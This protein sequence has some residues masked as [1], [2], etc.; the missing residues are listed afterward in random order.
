[1]HN[2]RFILLIIT[3]AIVLCTVVI[4]AACAD[5]ELVDLET[6]AKEAIYAIEGVQYADYEPPT[7]TFYLTVDS[8]LQE[9]DL[10]SLPLPTAELTIY[11]DSEL[12][13]RALDILYLDV[14]ANY[15]YLKFTRDEETLV[16]NLTITRSVHSE[17]SFSA[18]VVTTAP[19]CTEIGYQKR[20]CECGAN[21]ID[22]L[23]A[24]GHTYSATITDPTCTVS[25]YTHHECT[26]CGDYYNDNYVDPLSHS[27]IHHEAK[28][29]SCEEI[30]Y[31]EYDT[32]GRCDYSTY[33]ELPALNHRFVLSEI[34]VTCTT[35]GYTLHTCVRC[36]NNETTDIVPM[37]GHNL[38]DHPA[39]APTCTEQGW[40]AYETCSRCTYTS[41]V[42]LPAK[43]HSWDE[44]N[45]LVMPSIETEG[46]SRIS[47][48]NCDEYYEELIDKL[49]PS[50]GLSFEPIENLYYVVKGIGTC[51]DT[52]LVIPSYY[53][54]IVVQRIKTEAFKNCS[55][56]TSVVIPNTVT[57]I[58]QSAF[59][60][61]SSLK[62]VVLGQSVSHIED[63]AFLTA[64]L[65][66]DNIVTPS[67]LTSFINWNDKN[68]FFR[69]IDG[70]LYNGEG[71]ALVQYAL[72]K[73]DAS[74]TPP[75]GVNTI[76][77][78]ALAYCQN[79]E[80][81]TLSE[82]VTSI[83]K[84]VFRQCLALTT[85]SLPDTLLTLGENAFF[86]CTA[87]TLYEDD[88]AYY[89]GNDANHYLVTFRVKENDRTQITTR[90]DTKILYSFCF[91]SCFS[92]KEISI[93]NQVV[94]IGTGAFSGCSELY[95]IDIPNNVLYIDDRAFE[96]CISMH[97]ATIGTGVLSVGEYA[98][99][100][101]TAL[102]E[103]IIPKSLKTIA[104]AMFLNCTSLTSVRF[105]NG[106]LVIGAYAFDHCSSLEY[107]VLPSTLTQIG[108]CAFYGCTAITRVY[109]ESDRND[110]LHLR[111][112]AKNECLSSNDIYFYSAKA[113][114]NDLYSCW[115]YDSL[116]NI[117]HW[118]S[119]ITLYGNGYLFDTEEDVVAIT[120][121]R[122][123][124]TLYSFTPAISGTLTIRSKGAVD[125]KG[126][127]YDAEHNMLDSDD[128]SDVGGN[129]KI[130]YEVTGGVTYYINVLPYSNGYVGNDT[131]LIV[132]EGCGACFPGKQETITA[133]PLKESVYALPVL[134]REGYE[135]LGWYTDEACTL[136]AENDYTI[137][138]DN[139]KV[140]AKWAE[141][142]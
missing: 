115:H 26:R 39:Q 103:V 67:H 99:R 77:S 47:C 88:L 20:T 140:Y 10:S 142:T 9:L 6:E 89:L 83:G 23:P 30:G 28:A 105:Q 14:G 130:V 59:A 131:V 90:L 8:E 49:T 110:W 132:L 60:G 41:Q 86:G 113:P 117:E 74:Y 3:I 80:S 126:T 106:T 133:Y 52:D 33:V 72:G 17:H 45:T 63:K 25:G 44:G 91:A 141:I 102:A 122:D 68:T 46:T 66:N 107:V 40:D 61:C 108:T 104:P 109:Y 114:E 76:A 71:T 81:V 69:V 57:T 42:F 111:I 37:L 92:L 21:E 120:V 101:C 35:D 125:T 24:L 100:D 127:L 48:T 12:T 32:C 87:L 31:N 22:T 73:Q 75:T 121:H 97:S 38:T 93:T 7:N 2:K 13:R 51:T 78:Y 36:G 27:L 96:N 54:N 1:M 64:G 134:E 119:T 62:S 53:N 50:E 98:F 116:K 34:K 137:T 70:D 84:E 16:F 4:F 5:K 82:E 15:Y 124:T 95:A 129:F 29:A 43:G 18:W 136:P 138:K 56:L 19:T 85:V 55:Q 118:Q 128:D 135:F 58:E 94:F 11:Y 79:I 139:E 123:D 65:D 112:D